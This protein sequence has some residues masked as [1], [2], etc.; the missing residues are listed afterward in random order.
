MSTASEVAGKL[1]QIKA[2]K[3]SPQKPFVWAS[4]LRSPIYCDNRVVLSYPEIRRFIIDSFIA[5]TSSFAPF[6]MVAG[7]ATAG[8]AHGALIAERLELP[9]VYVRSSAKSHGRQNLIEGEIDRGTRVLVV[10]DLISTGGSCLKA[11]QAIREA[12]REVVGVAAIFTYG[13]EQAD[14]AFREAGCPFLALSN[15]QTLVEEAVKTNYIPASDQA[16]L[17]E[18]RKD[19]ERWWGEGKD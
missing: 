17:S 8:I 2:I 6:D 7:V 18:W 12:G 15:Y 10:E 4:G 5:Q 9:F 11:V 14:K 3:L 1:L 19:P 13:F 16:T